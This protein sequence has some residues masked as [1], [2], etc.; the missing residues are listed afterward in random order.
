MGEKKGFIFTAIAVTFLGIVTGLFLG[1]GLLPSPLEG[2]QQ[3]DERRTQST[4][5]KSFG[6]SHDEIPLHEHTITTIVTTTETTP[7]GFFHDFSAAMVSNT[8]QAV[9]P[10]PARAANDIWVIN[11]EFQPQIITVSVGTVVTWTNKNPEEHTVTSEDGL[12]N[13]RLIARGSTTNYTFTVPG[14]FEYYC[15]PH[16]EMTGKVI[17]R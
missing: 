8:T 12:F 16:K 17:V 13:L 5:T 14:T 2:L 3:Y 15:E 11:K 10:T 6:H 9:A 7:H 4:I 1:G